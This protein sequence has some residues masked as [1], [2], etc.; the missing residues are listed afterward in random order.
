M[1]LLPGSGQVDRNE[2]APK[3]AINVLREIAV[4][5]ARLGIATFRYDKRGVGAS[6]GDYF[7]TGFFDRVEDAKAALAWL[8][9]HDQVQSMKVFV[10]GHSEGSG[11]TMRS[12]GA[13]AD[14]AG[15]ILLTGW[16]REIGRDT[17]L[18][19]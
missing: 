6:E 9:E 17:S 1:L 8:K 4:Y 11:L 19:G 18:A 14:V 12:A 5:L 10:L 3:L 15:I 2:N 16:A 7:S 13:G